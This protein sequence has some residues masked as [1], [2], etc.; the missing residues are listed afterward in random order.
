MA[1]ILKHLSF[2]YGPD[3]ATAVFERV[4]DILSRHR[5]SLPSGDLTERDAI[6][7]TYGDQVMHSGEASLHTLHVFCKRHLKGLIST[8][9][10]LPFYP[11]TSDDGF[12]VVDYRKV[13][14][15]LGGWDD[16]YAMGDHF[17]LMFDAVINH[18]SAESDWFK[19]FLR[20]ETPYRD[21]FI[22]VEDSPDLSLVVRPRALP[23]LT[24]FLTPSGEKRVWTTFSGDQIDLNYANPE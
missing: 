13:D 8:I 1:D 7:I 18:I 11:W 24:S 19:G 3:R 4:Q 15:D 12:S 14:P 2:L 20:D 22:A 23:L 16:I 9:H 6:L 10:I 5:V 21:Y 17:R